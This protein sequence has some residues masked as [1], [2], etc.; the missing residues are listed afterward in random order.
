MAGAAT[1]AVASFVT[2]KCKTSWLVVV[3]AFGWSPTAVR[4][5][6]SDGLEDDIG[7][8]RFNWAFS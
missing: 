3:R 7:V 8:T 6:T 1:T 4:R 5:P 2:G